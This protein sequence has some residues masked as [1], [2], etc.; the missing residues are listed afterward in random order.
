MPSWKHAKN[1]NDY[2]ARNQY[3]L[4]QG[5]AKIDLAIYEHEFWNVGRSDIYQDDKI[6][7]PKRLYL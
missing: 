1:Y 4:R 3:I 6:A 5:E 2:I 7:N